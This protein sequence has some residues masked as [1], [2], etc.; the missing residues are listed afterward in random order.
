M[1]STDGV[2]TGRPKVSHFICRQM[3][4]LLMHKISKLE[5]FK[6]AVF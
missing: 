6:S 2:E 5:A 1:K 3:V 4:V